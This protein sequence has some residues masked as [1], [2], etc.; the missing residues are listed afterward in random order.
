MKIAISETNFSDEQNFLDNLRQAKTVGFDGVEI[1]ATS[2]INERIV[3]IAEACIQQQI[4]VSAIHIQHTELIHPEL[5]KREAAIAWVRRAMGHAIDLNAS[6]VI[7][8]PHY[9]SNPVLPDLKPYKSALELEAELLVTQLK[10]TLCDLAYAMGSHLF[11]QSVSQSESHLI[12]SVERANTIMGKVKNHPHLHLAIDAP[13]LSANGEDINAIIE[14]YQAS[15]G[16]IRI[17]INAI[18]F[19]LAALKSTLNSHE[20]Q[21]WITLYAS[22]RSAQLEDLETTVANLQQ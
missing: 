14:T 5:D 10:N 4:A 12:N 11:L 3:E 1:Q 15:I 22:D 19:N 6:G 2:E 7:F 16:H 21:G 13:A 17:N 18:D 8:L 9:Q 20:Y